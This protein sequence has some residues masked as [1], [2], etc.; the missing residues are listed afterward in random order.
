MLCWPGAQNVRDLGGRAL[1][2]GGRTPYGKVFRSAAP[3]H[4]TDEGWA[5]AKAAGVRTVVDLRNAPAE[6]QRLADHPVILPESLH[7]L[8]FVATPT[9]DPD[10]AEF[11]RV[12]GPFLDHPCC[13]ADNT[14]LAPERIAAALRT[15]ARAE[16]AVLVHCAGG[17]DRTGMI[18]AMLLHIAGA[19]ED[20]I[21]DDYATGW[22]GAGAYAGHAW[23]YDADK[24]NW[25]RHPHAPTDA[26][27]LERQ[28]AERV[29]ALR[30]WIATFDAAELLAL[31]DV[32]AIRALLAPT[33]A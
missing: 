15:V 23:V 32:R 29:P 24:G 28:V 13:W 1:R 20:A 33:A 8:I 18:S 2:G 4:L 3:E 11:L 7:G 25:Q 21:I 9:E 31:D 14:R 12:C 27:V 6:T 22:R 16:R 5:A 19:T 10:D 17:R 30:E 26:A